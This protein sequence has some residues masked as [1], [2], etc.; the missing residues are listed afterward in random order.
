MNKTSLRDLGKV[1]ASWH[2][3]QPCHGEGDGITQWSYKPCYAGQPKMDR[4]WG[5]VLTKYGPLKKG[6]AKHSSILALR[7]PW[8]VWKGKNMTPENHQLNGHES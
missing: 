3:S 1:M 8:T 2:G 4:S 5:T 6:M 7:T